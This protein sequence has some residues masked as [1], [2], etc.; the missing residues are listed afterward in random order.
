[1]DEKPQF[2][3]E[4]ITPTL[5]NFVLHVWKKWYLLYNKDVLPQKRD[6]VFYLTFLSTF[7]S[8]FKRS[9]WVLSLKV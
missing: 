9:T 1:M 4:R 6:P 2:E 3:Q 5:F 7:Y 8:L